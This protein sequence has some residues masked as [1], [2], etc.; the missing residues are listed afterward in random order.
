[1]SKTIIFCS[2]GTWNGPGGDKDD[3]SPPSNVW[4]LFL[5]LKGELDHDSLLQASEQEKT[6]AG[7]GGQV[8]KYIHGVGSSIGPLDKIFG[9]VF[10]S[11][12]IER[13]VRGY[14]F[15]SRNYQPGDRIV[16]VGFSRGAYTARALGG[17]ITDMGLLNPAAHDLTDKALAY[18]LGSMAW[19]EHRAK[20][21]DDRV[22]AQNGNRSL[23][24]K[25]SD[26]LD[27]LPR[28]MSGKLSQNEL[29][30]AQDGILAIAVWDT[31][32][33][34]G[35]PLYVDHDDDR[36]DVFRF[37]D[38]NLSEKVQFGFHAIS[39]DE[40]RGDFVPTLWTPRD[41]VRQVVFPG[42][43][44]DV[45]GGYEASGLSNGALRWMVS[46]LSKIGVLF[47]DSQ[48]L[49]ADNPADVGHRPWAKGVF[50]FRP[51]G[52]RTI[53][54]DPAYAGKLLFHSSVKSR[55]AARPSTWDPTDGSSEYVPTVLGTV[56]GTNTA[57]E[58]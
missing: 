21:V 11:G 43:H 37:A 5:H 47:D 30:P 18:R 57:W 22:A 26:V 44:S 56:I 17:L 41:N 49:A 32:G 35:I 7:E 54:E 8:A 24:D 38:T 20:R 9:G 34:L 50:E 28:F 6:L 15:V 16:L 48:A 52:P 51:R 46:S 2:D 29:V 58:A 42:A 25:L 3:T 12:T 14:T 13:I 33:S 4:K 19:S 39:L 23:V 40:Q 55:L 36:V 45:G 31:V 53:L 1:M 10:G 27:G